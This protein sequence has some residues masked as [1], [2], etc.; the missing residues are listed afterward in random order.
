M[1]KRNMVK[2]IK[3]FINSKILRPYRRYRVL[4]SKEYRR[5]KQDARNPKIILL[6]TPEHGNLGDQAIRLAEIDFLQKRT[7]GKNIYEFTY[8]E[9]KLCGC[10]LIERI[11]PEDV[12][13][14]HGGGFIGTLYP[15][16]QDMLL[17][18]LS[19]LSKNHIVIFPQTI[20]FEDFT[21]GIDGNR[22]RQRFI[23]TLKSCDDITVFTRDK[24]SYYFMKKEAAFPTVNCFYV[25]DIVTSLHYPVNAA[26]RSRKVM[27]C[28]R[29]DGEKILDSRTM[30]SIIQWLDTQN[31]PYFYSDTIVNRRIRRKKCQNE[32]YRKLAEFASAHLVI[33]DRLHGMIFSAITSTPCIAFDNISHKISGGYEWLQSL[34]YIECVPEDM[35]NIKF[36]NKMY[37]LT[38]CTYSSRC[39]ENHYD[40]IYNY[41]AVR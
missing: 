10:E 11:K 37:S 30:D 32:V 36:L 18:I 5:F 24:E 29:K 19:Q 14:I 20:Y 2:K 28:F 4:N 33:T 17:D 41:I 16:E 39:F 40:L 23:D 9:L 31:I 22:E 6:D 26:E 1:N 38:E 15:W 8:N 21:D 25:P 34:G 27:L 7:G 12:I 13:L 35:L 3:T